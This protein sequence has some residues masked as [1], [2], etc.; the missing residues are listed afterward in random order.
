MS[1]QLWHGDRVDDTYLWC[2]V[3]FDLNYEN[4]KSSQSQ[5]VRY[6]TKASPQISR[7]GTLLSFK[8][9]WRA[10]H[11]FK[12][13]SEQ[14]N[15][16]FCVVLLQI[17]DTFWNWPPS[18]PLYRG[19]RAFELIIASPVAEQD[20]DGRIGYAPVWGRLPP[21]PVISPSANSTRSFNFLQAQ[22]D[23]CA[24]EHE[25]CSRES[26]LLP[27]RVLDL[28]ISSAAVR[29]VKLTEPHPGTP[30]KYIAL[31]YCWG[32]GNRLRTTRSN[33]SELLQAVDEEE[34]PA[35]V[36]DA[37]EVARY[38]GV[39]Y[40][41]VDALCIIQ[42]DTQ[43]WIHESARMAA[44]YG[45]AFLTISASSVASSRLSFLHAS[46]DNGEVL[47]QLE[48]SATSG[49]PRDCNDSDG[50]TRSGVLAVRKTVC[51]GFHQTP[52]RGIVDPSM[53]RAW[54]LQEYLLSPRVVSFSTDEVQWICRTLRACECGNPEELDTP[55]MEELQQG[56]KRMQSKDTNPGDFEMM[57]YCSEFW[58]RVV[59]AYCRRELSQVRD[60][61]PALSGVAR[62]YART[63]DEIRLAA[64]ATTA[65]TRWP[66]RYLAGLWEA[67]FHRELCWTSGDN[68]QDSAAGDYC[69]PTWSWAS[70]AGEVTPHIRR[71]GPEFVPR[72]EILEAA[73]TLL[74]PDDPFGQVVREGTHLRV[75]GAVLEAK[76]QLT[77]R[78]PSYLVEY[79]TAYGHVFLD[80]KVEAVLLDN[81]ATIWEQ[82]ETAAAA[83]AETE[84]AEAPDLLGPVKTVRRRRGWSA[85]TRENM[86]HIVTSGESES[87]S[88]A[89]SE[90]EMWERWESGWEWEQSNVG[91]QFTVW[92][93]H[94]ADGKWGIIQSPEVLVLGRPVGEAQEVYERIGI[95]QARPYK[96]QDNIDPN[97]W[98]QW[99]EHDREYIRTITIV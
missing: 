98:I 46:R 10:R 45:R 17:V 79:Q 54:M 30:G 73:C 40:L 6:S 38:L 39:R 7:K 92:L 64:T 71:R 41:W 43:D 65:A 88:D 95:M 76:M 42:D 82:Q 74:N 14:H 89:G 87:G 23:T 25:N 44:V 69:G 48:K 77:Q 80:C 78:S 85:V 21:G 26:P 53:C 13:R 60:K 94:L 68:S 35:T 3:C 2:P 93:L 63:L 34:L 36:R 61:L 29:S 52:Y 70:I 28:G 15:C 9:W 83:A 66:P 4:I 86:G 24:R 58:A 16:G 72:A 59:E 99:P 62:E 84:N 47:L 97:D 55:R 56:I 20:V 33:I 37:I 27:T 22:L 90:N 50:A 5:E 1:F 57:L 81:P 8:L 96:S 31:S 12:Y 51:S 18:G 32:N 19:T 67:D 75:R 11:D 91:K 49:R